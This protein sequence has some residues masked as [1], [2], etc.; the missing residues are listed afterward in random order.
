MPRHSHDFSPTDLGHF[1]LNAHEPIAPQVYAQLRDKIL[2]M[3]IRPEEEISE[4]RLAL[5]AGVS[6][7]PIRQVVK[8]LVDDGLLVSYPSRGTFV[9]RIDVERVREALVVRSRLEPHL[10]GLSAAADDV[11]EIVRQ[12]RIVLDRHSAALAINDVSMAYKCDYQFHE[13]I[14]S[15]GTNSFIWEVLR[16]ARSEADR[17]HALGK[18]REHSLQIALNQHKTIVEAIECRDPERAHQAMQQHMEHN[19]KLLTTVRLHNPDL[20][21]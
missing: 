17:L 6:R 2:S 10:A 21:V 14:C 20:F 15:N 1:D 9:S 18:H 8:Q 4:A 13:R 19:E 7:T 3:E 11:E 12:L 16:K 5:G